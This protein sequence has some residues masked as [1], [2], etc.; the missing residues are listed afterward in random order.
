MHVAAHP[1]DLVKAGIIDS[2]QGLLQRGRIAASSRPDP[3]EPNGL[4]AKSRTTMIQRR[5]RPGW[6]APSYFEF[7]RRHGE[8]RK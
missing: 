5:D 3:D 7:A 6:P 4:I 8:R 2:G 1:V